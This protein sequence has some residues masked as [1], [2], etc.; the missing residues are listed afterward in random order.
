MLQICLSFP[1]SQI[2]NTC[3]LQLGSQCPTKNIVLI[4]F[5]SPLSHIPAPRPALIPHFNISVQSTFALDAARGWLGGE[6]HGKTVVDLIPKTCALSEAA[7]WNTLSP[8]S[9][10]LGVGASALSLVFTENRLPED[11]LFPQRATTTHT[12]TLTPPSFFLPLFLS[13]ALLC[14]N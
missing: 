6:G 11:P 2:F 3:K 7:D 5:F 13:N 8:D 4:S 1:K 14:S 12:H 10:E 9:T